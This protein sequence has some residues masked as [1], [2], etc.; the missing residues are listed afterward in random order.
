MVLAIL[1]RGKLNGCCRALVVVIVAMVVARGCRMYVVCGCLQRTAA[2]G[3][4]WQLSMR[5]WDCVEGWRSRHWH[6]GTTW[7]AVDRGGLLGLA[8]LFSAVHR[9]KTAQVTTLLASMSAEAACTG[10][11]TRCCYRLECLVGIMGIGVT[12]LIILTAI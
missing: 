3:V 6:H 2:A 4:T 9:R 12:L 8:G 1:P 7:L 11:A 10:G 5:V